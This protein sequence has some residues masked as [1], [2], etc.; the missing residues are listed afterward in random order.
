[1]VPIFLTMQ[2]Q[3]QLN[4]KIQ[5]SSSNQVLVS[6]DRVVIDA[7]TRK[8]GPD[9]WARMEDITHLCCSVLISPQV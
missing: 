6:Y 1:M 5:Y 3:Q 9:H 2:Q 4:N 7:Y 8:F